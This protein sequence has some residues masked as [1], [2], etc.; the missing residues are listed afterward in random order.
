LEEIKAMYLR[1]TTQ[2]INEINE[3]E[4]GIFNAIAFVIADSL[5]E[6]EDVEKLKK[7]EKWFSKNLKKPDRFNL[8]CVTL[9]IMD[10][11]DEFRRRKQK[12]KPIKKH[13]NIPHKYL[14]INYLFN[15]LRADLTN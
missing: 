8:F 5:T 6:D 9:I 1:F 14:I 10:A 3:T 15:I 13:K 7:I 12:L 2:F 4:F 11:D